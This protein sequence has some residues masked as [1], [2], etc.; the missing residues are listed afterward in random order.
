MPAVVPVPPS[1]IDSEPSGPAAVEPERTPAADSLRTAL[2]AG[3]SEF[4]MPGSPLLSS[5][6]WPSGP[7]LEATSFT[8]VVQ[9]VDSVWSPA[10]AASADSVS[11]NLAPWLGM[12]DAGTSVGLGARKAGVATAGFFTRLSRSIAG[13]F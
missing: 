5:V 6:S 7:A 12:A 10:A 9:T 11:A 3:R 1:A 2:G 8:A 4:A 13:V